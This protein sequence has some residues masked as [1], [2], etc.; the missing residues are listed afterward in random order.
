[1]IMKMLMVLA[2]CAMFGCQMNSG[3]DVSGIERNLRYFKD[4]KTGLC[5]AALNSASAQMYE[6]TSIAC[7]PCDSLDSIS[8]GK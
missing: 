1:M 4:P 2:L 6:V 7:V 8:L 3:S 5:F